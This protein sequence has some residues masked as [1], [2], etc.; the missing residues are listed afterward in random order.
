MRRHLPCN[1]TLLATHLLL[2]LL[3]LLLARRLPR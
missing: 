2:L 3:L 1:L